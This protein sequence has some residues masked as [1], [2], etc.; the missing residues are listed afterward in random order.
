MTEG[1]YDASFESEV[2]G[3]VEDDKAEF[4]ASTASAMITTSTT[5]AKATSATTAE[6]T[7]T[8]KSVH[9]SGHQHPKN[10]NKVST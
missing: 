10:V 4:V 5:T 8:A 7:K 9:Y 1:H 2:P 3:P 6:S